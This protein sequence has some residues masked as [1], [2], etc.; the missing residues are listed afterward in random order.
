MTDANVNK[1]P[2]REVKYKL[3]LEAFE[4]VS[5]HEAQIVNADGEKDVT[6]VSNLRKTILSKK[7]DDGKNYTVETV[8][9]TVDDYEQATAILSGN[10]EHIWE[11]FTARVIN[12]MLQGSARQKLAVLAQGP[13]KAILSQIDSLYADGTGAFSEEE[14]T[15]FVISRYKAKG[16]VA[17]DF[18][19]SK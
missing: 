6:L 10:D 1:K 14:A 7:G 16:L 5:E 12:P 8:E 18:V 19:L 15:E 9:V 13:T 3:D 11:L 4:R 2:G 17:E